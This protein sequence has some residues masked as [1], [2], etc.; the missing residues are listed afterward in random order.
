MGPNRDNGARMVPVLALFSRFQDVSP[1][2]YA[3][4][5]AGG[6]VSF[7][8]PCVLPL[9]PGYLSMVTGL[10]LAT[11]REGSRAHL[12]RIAATTGLFVAGFGV[13]FVL[14]GMSAS[15]LGG[16]LIDN[17]TVLTRLS[18]AV[19]LAMALFLL[20]SMFLR[21]PW[22][23]QEKRFHPQLSRFGVAAPIVAGVAFGFGWSPCI[24]PILGS[25][26]GIAARQDRAW[27]GGTLLAVYTLGLGL[28][29]L[30]TGL[31]LGSL[32]GPLTFVKRHLNVIVAGS[33]IVLAVFGVL[34]IF[35]QLTRVTSELQ[36]ALDHAGLDWLVNLG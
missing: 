15:T 29:F 6:F 30:F 9:V 35:D 25:I 36:Q 31:A 10:D 12:A 23:Y 27:A 33:A 5:F 20:G 18:G 4:A 34:L 16:R 32:S 3:L 24:G 26:L 22:L 21:A 11:L 17:K 28:P 1:G 8:S 14:L 13:V 2:A 7:L 19:M